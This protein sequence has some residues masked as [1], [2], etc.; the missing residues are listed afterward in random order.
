MWITYGCGIPDFK[1]WRL[2]TDGKLYS[3][4][5][6]QCGGG[7][8]TTTLRGTVTAHASFGYGVSLGFNNY[9]LVSSAGVLEVN[10][11]YSGSASGVYMNPWE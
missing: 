4:Y 3:E 5:S 10:P 11:Q 9:A 2:D 7:A 8:I 1:R 6:D